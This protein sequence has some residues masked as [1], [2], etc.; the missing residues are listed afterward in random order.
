[1]TTLV[2][3][4][5]IRRYKD[6]PSLMVDS[7]PV[8][9]WDTCSLLYFSTI[10]ERKAY[11]EFEWDKKLHYLIVN[12]QVYSVTSSIVYKE[13]NKHHEE[14]LNKEIE[15]EKALK[16]A[17]KSYGEILGGQKKVD[18]N[19]GMSVLNL[20]RARGADSHLECDE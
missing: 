19:K 12:N 7:K 17:M 14:F 11:N 5:E 3:P 6:I 18:L 9:F 13:F 4:K 8:I 15:R 1:M 10:I 2:I 20:S 16:S